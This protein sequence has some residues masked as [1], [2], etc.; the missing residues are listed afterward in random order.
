MKD[1]MK[2]GK[3]KFPDD[4]KPDDTKPDE[5]PVL[6]SFNWRETFAARQEKEK[7]ILDAIR[8]MP[9]PAGLPNV[10]ALFPAD[11]ANIEDIAFAPG[12]PLVATVAH[13]ADKDAIKFWD[14]NEMKVGKTIDVKV[15]GTAPAS[16]RITR[17]SPS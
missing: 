9:R 14:L 15:T 10:L 16:R 12:S 4:K 13:G 1:K 2:G 5:K 6:P 17:C 8:K 11:A 7:E 3:D